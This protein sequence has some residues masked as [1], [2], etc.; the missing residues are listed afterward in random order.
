MLGNEKTF[1]G[2]EIGEI[3]SSRAESTRSYVRS[4]KGVS[5]LTQTEKRSVAFHKEK[6]KKLP[7]VKLR[8]TVA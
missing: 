5:R 8:K 2:Q 7:K 6:S 1:H 3:S 4:Q